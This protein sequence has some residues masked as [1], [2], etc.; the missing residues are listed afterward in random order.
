MKR[1]VGALLI[2]LMVMSEAHARPSFRLSVVCFGSHPD[3]PRSISVAHD[4]AQLLGSQIG[5]DFK[6]VSI[7]E[8][9]LPEIDPRLEVVL[10]QG[11]AVRNSLLDGSDLTLMIS[12]KADMNILGVSY[13]GVAGIRPAAIVAHMPTLDK[14]AVDVVAHELGH[15]LGASHD[16]RGLM[17]PAVYDDKHTSLLSNR[18][19]QQIKEHLRVLE[20]QVHIL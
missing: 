4:A 19:K 5:V 1:I 17:T 7:R 18:C 14:I 9:P 13:L 16:E 15:A 6:I 8:M 11:I 20:G 10:S 12:P 3:C 2:I